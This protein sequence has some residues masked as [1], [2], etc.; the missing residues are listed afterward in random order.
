MNGQNLCVEHAAM[1]ANVVQ[2][3]QEQ[4]AAMINFLHEQIEYTMG[5][6][7]SGPRIA[8]PQ[9]PPT[10]VHRGNVTTNQFRIDRSVIGAVNTA[11]VAKIEVS[12]NNI[13][14]QDSTDFTVAIKELTEAFAANAELQDSK[15]E[16]LLEILSYL[17]SQATLPEQQ[18]QKTL[19]KRMLSRVPQII[20]SA[21]DLTA[22]WT[23]HHQALIS[24]FNLLS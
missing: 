1:M 21:A 3:Q 4:S 9:P 17:S 2:R 12:M 7:S 8:I 22:I 11:E 5:V 24:F 16:E 18:Q 14:N 6:P 20:A 10:V 19:I 15:K 13:Q 23:A